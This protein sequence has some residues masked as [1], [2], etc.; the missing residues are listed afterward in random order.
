MNTK[1]IVCLS[2]DGVGPE[3]IDLSREL[4]TKIK[5]M[6]ETNFAVEQVAFG[7]AAIDAYGHPFAKEVQDALKDADAILL[8]AIGHPKY[9]DCPV[10]PEAGLLAAR[11]A[12]NLYANIRGLKVTP[13]LAKY[14]PLKPEI[15]TGTD[16]IIVRELVGGAYFGEKQLSDDAAVDEMAYSREMIERIVH[17]GFKLA[18]SR[19]KKMLSV[20]KANV[21]STSKL[22]RKIVGEIASEYPEVEVKHMYVD[23]MAMELISNPTAYDVVVMENLFGDILSDELA[24]IAGS[25]GLLPS[26]SFGVDGIALYEPAHG[27]APDIAGKDLVNPV[28][29][30]L[31]VAMM[32]RESFSEHVAA[33]KIETVIA[34]VM[35]AGIVT[36]DLDKVNGVA[37]S[38]FVAEILKRL[39][40]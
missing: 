12:L 7:G 29:M 39:E 37:T 36:K 20:D 5:P 14:S 13:D 23:A 10:R 34:E 15:I 1:K 17:Y 30:F 22:W 24:A 26:G 16:I 2:G 8:G 27:S 4:L 33:E 19:S 35:A 28:A 38:Q 25:L 31:S 11:K 32:L 9:D 3:L 6:L 40:V 18:M 21:L